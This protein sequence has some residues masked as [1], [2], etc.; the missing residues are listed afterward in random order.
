MV[1]LS[2]FIKKKATSILAPLFM[3]ALL[4]AGSV[5]SYAV[6]SS[7]MDQARAIAA[8]WYLR[9][10]NNGSDYLDQLQPASMSDLE[11]KLKNTEKENIKGFKA[12]ALPSGYN[13]W[14]KDELIKYWSETFFKES[15][16]IDEKG[17][18]N[19]WIK[20]KVA[21]AIRNDVKV[22]APAAASAPAAETPAPSEPQS[23]PNPKEA[24]AAAAML[25]Q[26]AEAAADDAEAQIAEQTLADT[27]P[28][29]EKGSGTWVYI[30]ILCILVAIVIALV[31]YASR[32]MKGQAQ[33]G[34][35]GRNA[36]RD[37]ADDFGPS[38]KAEYRPSLSDDTRMREKYAETLANKAEE[39][40]LLNRKIADL[41]AEAASLKAENRKL[42]EEM[43]R[44][45]TSAHQAAERNHHHE[46]HHDS[47][48]KHEE[49]APAPRAR[50]IYLG[51]VNS[52]GIFVRADRHAVEGQSIYRLSTFDG[53][54]GTFTVINSPVV[55]DMVMDDP[56][57]WVADGC[58][59]KDIFDTE[60]RSRIVT[61]VPGLAVF[62]DGAWR[63]ERKAKIHY[64]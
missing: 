8:K 10:I 30:M 46:H 4:L 63:V 33:K 59:A 2:M 27:Q 20:G 42:R 9:Y 18:G 61:E 29:K 13:S 15:K 23:V 32:S 22:G 25:A 43:D 40:R 14:D 38:P 55:D 3:G 45:A 36:E 39:I 62:R 52:R 37:D 44:R 50:E 64:E 54:S 49:Q 60:G 19:Q 5:D 56:G 47:H 16:T 53:E 1:S 35:S 26:E 34:D 7:E 11:S 58:F 28:V 48:R 31:V 6:T 51:R 21:S 12:T 24:A 41:E 57:R 17:R